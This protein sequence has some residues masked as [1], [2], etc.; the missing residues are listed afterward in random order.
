M[1]IHPWHTPASA[2]T[3][4]IPFAGWLM[5]ALRP[6]IFVE[7][8]T[9][10][11]ASY[12][13]FCQAVEQR[14]L[15]TVC[16]AVDTW[17][18]DE[19]TKSYGEEIFTELSAIHDRHFSGFSHLVR[20]TFDDALHEFGDGSIDLLHIDGLHTYK[21]VKHDFE[22]WLPKMSAS[23]VILFH[24][25]MER[26]R[27]FGVWKLW[28]ELA[29]RYPSFQ[30]RHS[31]GLGVLLVGD[32]V[33]ASLRQ[34][35]EGFSGDDA[36]VI[37]ELFETLGSN[38]KLR[39]DI[40]WWK[41]EVG[42]LGGTIADLNHQVNGLD[43][44][45]AALN[46]EL[47]AGKYRIADVEAAFAEKAQQL[48]GREVDVA[49]L[50]SRLAEADRLMVERDQ[51]SR[52]LDAATSEQRLRIAELEGSVAHFEQRVRDD[53]EAAAQAAERLASLEQDLAHRDAAA[54]ESRVQLGSMEKTIALRNE[55]VAS[56]E[57][58]I[59]MV[60]AASAERA[61]RVE[62]LEQ[63]VLD[64]D[65][66]AGEFEEA[67]RVRDAAAA[68]SAAHVASLDRILADKV[69][70]LALLNADIVSKAEAASRLL[71]ALAERDV[72]LAAR[73]AALTER[74]ATLAD[75]DAKLA[76]RD[77]ALTERAREVSGL[78]QGLAQKTRTVAALE[79]LVREGNAVAA[80]R[81][82]QLRAL[83]CELMSRDAA[84][85]AGKDRESALAQVMTQAMAARDAQLAEVSAQRDEL[86]TQ[87]LTTGHRIGRKLNLW[88][89]RF[90][91]VGTRRGRLVS[92]SGRFAEITLRE[93]L[94]KAIGSMF[95]YVFRSH[96]AQPM[97]E[98]P[99][100][101]FPI[102]ST[103]GAGNGAQP[104]VQAD[105]PEFANFIAS[106]EP[107]PEQLE[108]QAKAAEAFAYRPLISVILP[109]Y[110]L[111]L[112]VLEETIASLEA[113][114]YPH[115]QGCLVWSDV[116]DLDGWRWLQERTANDARFRIALLAENGGISRNSNAALELADGEFLALLDHDD[117][118][119]P[120]A[121]HD[122]VA[123]LQSQ[124]DLDFI[125][126]DK[127]SISA[128]G[129]LRQNALFKPGWSPEMLHSVNYLTHL[130]IMRTS[131]VREIDGWNP[132]TDG[133]QDWDIFFRITERTH[134]IAR[135]NS[136]M[137]HWRILPTST[138]TGLAAKPYAALGQ[139]RS[140][141]S[142]FKRQGLPATVLPT[143][144][145]MFRVEW[146]VRKGS[147][148]VVVFQSGSLSQLVTVL[149]S[150][151]ACQ[152][153]VIDRIFV[154]MEASPTDALRAFSQ[155][156][157]DRL[158]MLEVAQADWRGALSAVVDDLHGDA[159]LLV[160]GRVEGL[161]QTLPQE[162]AGWVGHHP[163]IAWA[164]AVILDLDSRVLEAGRVLGDNDESAPLFRDA[165][166]HS[167]GW[168]GGPLWYRNASA[169]SPV[170]VAI[171]ASL[172]AG[173]LAE[174]P[175][176]QPANFATLCRV[177]REGSLRGLVNPHARA[178]LR[179]PTESEWRNEGHFFAADP[180]FNP[181]FSQVSPLSMNP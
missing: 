17:Q 59:S 100:L 118:L 162:L 181:S 90:A 6:K 50:L 145:G 129:S 7:L 10:R 34:L 151:R 177:L 14:G 21:A 3:G 54:A 86:A 93:G 36:P 119:T 144:E 31:H 130:N 149:D 98:S 170:A 45:V 160:D 112:E 70:D 28:A 148:D 168:F 41:A 77:A 180:Y 72:I 114:T 39:A 169:A 173:A 23:G 4:H 152:Q 20:S 103:A 26:G 96:A 80:E 150:L 99:S 97:L 60:E 171:K 154:V 2:W 85:A 67:I 116:H 159:V 66:A 53:A 42:K 94:G 164:S 1:L 74:D 30:F 69:R 165:Y 161:S 33:P 123:L 117:T 108:Q 16:Y 121:F 8:G 15:Q 46:Q 68:S 38:I 22:T 58:A 113:Q 120:W 136:I 104:S 88:R 32:Q 89:A 75:R 65:A 128:D 27:G 52:Q 175:P 73:D 111:P 79:A 166:L 11:G 37:D 134:R 127:D 110:R 137:Y 47:A 24:D 176:P 62:F 158:V 105:H 83:E 131:L 12:L 43:A 126:S 76:D 174:V 143:A 135:L 64:R 139:L 63:A 107:T 172:L 167:Y 55:A 56:L 153:E 156:W 57:Q 71:E 141:Q 101:R 48:A 91:P 35:A 84:I 178:H 82:S 19:H 179:E 157:G 61:A 146:P 115:W 109:I 132:D 133:A 29:K 122:V 5:D 51:L 147:V 13:A 155:V 106:R 142:H 18:G 9:H 125:Y 163:S 87:M 49:S 95:R 81:T 124:P 140:Q 138:A 44:R 92:L 102:L 40:E 78:E 25:T